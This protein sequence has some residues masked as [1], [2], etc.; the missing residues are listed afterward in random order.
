ML[1]KKSVALH[2]LLSLQLTGLVYSSM[3]HKI[4][5][6]VWIVISIL[7]IKTLNKQRLIG[8]TGEKGEEKQKA[9]GV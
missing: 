1:S 2:V 7:F 6:L 5:A 3:I 9:T 4:D 8:V